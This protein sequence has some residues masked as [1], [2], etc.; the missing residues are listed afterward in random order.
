MAETITYTALC[1]RLRHAPSIPVF[2][3][4]Q[5]SAA[6]IACY[7]PDWTPPQKQEQIYQRLR[8]CSAQP[9]LAVTVILVTDVPHN[10]LF[11]DWREAAPDAAR[12]E[13]HGDG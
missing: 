13:G 4:E 5:A 9:T 1:V 3:H 11:G 6:H 12:E 7:L 2:V 10:Q 8:D